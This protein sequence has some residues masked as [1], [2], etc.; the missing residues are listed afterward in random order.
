MGYTDNFG[1]VTSNECNLYFEE[2]VLPELGCIAQDGFW[3]ISIELLTA[4]QKSMYGDDYTKIEHVDFHYL[5]KELEW[6]SVYEFEQAIEYAITYPESIYDKLDNREY[7]TRYSTGCEEA[8]DLPM[9]IDDWKSMRAKA[10]DD[11]EVD[12]YDFILTSSVGLV[13]LAILLCLCFGFYYEARRGN[14]CLSAK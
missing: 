8:F 11:E 1:P 3:E 10:D 14:G 9:H 4:Y 2:E 6:E 5:L 13:I 12:M 7:T